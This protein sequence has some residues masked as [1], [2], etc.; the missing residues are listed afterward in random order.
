MSIILFD[1]LCSQPAENIKFHGGGEYTKTVFR[2]FC[3]R[4]KERLADLRVCYNH[5]LFLDDWI[6]ELLKTNS[7]KQYNVKSKKDICELLKTLAE[8]DKV[9]FYAGI[10][11]GYEGITFPERVK[12]IGTFHGLRLI[13]KPIDKN[14]IYYMTSIQD[15][16]S[17]VANLFFSNR[18]KK[19]IFNAFRNSMS[20]FDLIITVSEW[21]KYSIKIN[22]PD[23]AKTKKIIRLYPPVKYTDTVIDNQ[24]KNID[25]KY[26]LMIS[27]NRWLK[28]SYRGVL[29]L[30]SLFTK[31]FL[32]GYNVH[33][34]GGLPNRISKK[35]HNKER[36]QLFD[37]VSSMELEKAYRNCSVFFYPTLNEGF[38]SPPLEAMQY[39]KTCL[40]S[41]VCSLTEIYGDA[42]YYCNPYDQ[43]E[44]ENRIVQAV[45]TRKDKNVISQRVG[46]IDA[47][48]KKDMQTLIDII[49]EE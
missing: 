12:K 11:Y 36:F 7:I 15:Y 37:Y 29:A 48:Q 45:D 16:K 34:L 10:A 23:V 4:K 41:A 1:L 28:N 27:G 33:V 24:N 46:Y 40:V 25:E 6:L 19:R 14:I 42:V 32:R 44:M 17:L 5:N 30:D 31:G 35:L 8:K 3:L 38:G 18:L 39:G 47:M 26:I 43:Q 9:V 21:S 20:K 2:E 49:S 13:E 22:F